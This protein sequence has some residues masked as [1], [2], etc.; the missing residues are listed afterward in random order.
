MSAAVVT[1]LSYNY[2]VL[3]LRNN[4]A[5]VLDYRMTLGE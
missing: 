4:A 5:L 2:R 3:D 1:T